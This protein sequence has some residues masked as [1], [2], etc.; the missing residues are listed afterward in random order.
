M[1]SID[2]ITDLS[3]DDLFSISES[4]EQAKVLIDQTDRYAPLRMILT[5]LNSQIE[6]FKKSNYVIFGT[7][8]VEG[9]VKRDEKGSTASVKVDYTSRDKKSSI[10]GEIEANQKGKV[11]GSVT[12]R[13][14]FRDDE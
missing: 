9:T 6:Q 12:V 8:A 10:R 1:Y 2:A 13:R 14:E 3:Y 4:K 11:S 7:G 5:N